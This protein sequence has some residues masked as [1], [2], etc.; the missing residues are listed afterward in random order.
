MC[1]ASSLTS[2]SLACHVCSFAVLS[3]AEGRI[4]YFI[5]NI[6]FLGASVVSLDRRSVAGAC[7]LTSRSARQNMWQR[8]PRPAFF[9][10]IWRCFGPW[11]VPAVENEDSGNDWWTALWKNGKRP[12][13][14]AKLTSVTSNVLHWRVEPHFAVQLFLWNLE[15]VCVSLVLCC[16]QEWWTI[17]NRTKLPDKQCDHDRALNLPSAIKLT[18]TL[19][20]FFS[21]RKQRTGTALFLFHENLLVYKNVEAEI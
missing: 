9:C 11:Q 3:A 15:T 7:S 14:R 21:L 18:R 5:V 16:G 19:K 12:N 4:W 6:W 20:T 8:L 2:A 17:Y 13:D 1:F 10:K